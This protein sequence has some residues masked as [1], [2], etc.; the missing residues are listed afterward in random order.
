MLVSSTAMGLG[1]ALLAYSCQDYYNAAL[2]VVERD[3]ADKLKR[4]RTPTKNLRRY[5][6]AWSIL[7]GI[8]F[9]G[10]WFFLDSIVFGTLAA[11][12]LAMVPWHLVRQRAARR[13][14]KIEEQ[15]SDA[16]VT[17]SSGIKAGLSLVQSLDILAEQ[18]PNPI[19][20]EFRQI[21]G[22]YKVGK[23]LERTLAEAKER[24]R[25]ETFVLFAASLMASRES[26]GKLNETVDRI[27]HSIRE[28]QRLER[29]VQSETAQARKSAVYMAIAPFLILIAYYFMDPANTSRLFTT[30]PG[31]ILL[32]FSI[33]LNI[34]AYF[35]A[36]IILNPD[37]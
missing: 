15:M 14:E 24:L 18:C 19:R 11:V 7:L 13:R 36:R 5:L 12:L 37:I 16:M 33:V 23:P 34:V 20:D 8:A 1:S 30:V 17:L 3:L 2:D 21:I 4:L 29:K 35:W 27:A 28:L 9:F 26:G 31:Q 10:N 22:E 32:S 6:I 25:S